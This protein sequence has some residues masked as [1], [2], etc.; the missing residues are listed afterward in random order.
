MS[1][2]GILLLPSSIG[3]GSG[4]F[5]FV[6]AL[7][8]VGLGMAAACHGYLPSL[9]L[10]FLFRSFHLHVFLFFVARLVPYDGSPSQ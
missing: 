9:A 8:L 2:S 3:V 7:L 10:F 4:R 1:V 5:F 6:I